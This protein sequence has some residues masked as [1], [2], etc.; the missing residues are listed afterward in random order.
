MW[1][2]DMWRGDGGNDSDNR[3]AVTLSKRVLGGGVNG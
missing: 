2:G 1:F 3:L